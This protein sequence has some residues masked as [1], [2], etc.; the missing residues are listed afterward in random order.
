MALEEVITLEC[1]Q[2]LCITLS[3]G[4]YP[5][6][7]PAEKG[8]A[9]AVTRVRTKVRTKR[10]YRQGHSGD[11]LRA[12]PFSRMLLPTSIGKLNPKWNACASNRELIT[13]LV[14]LIKRFRSV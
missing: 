5:G 3:G 6:G 4:H 1:P 13:F 11:A 14:F 7:P 9:A 8:T 2:K 12:Q 10:I